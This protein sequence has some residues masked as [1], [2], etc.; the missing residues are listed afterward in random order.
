LT[1]VCGFYL[2]VPDINFLIPND[3]NAKGLFDLTFLVGNSDIL[4]AYDNSAS[5]SI[6]SAIEISFSN[7]FAADLGTGLTAGSE[8]A[9]LNISGLTFNT[10]GRIK[11]QIY[12]SVSTITFPTIIVTGYDKIARNSI[13]RIQF[14]NLQT[15]ATGVT[16]YCKLG[17]SLSYYHYGGVKGYIY[18]PVS[19]VLGPTTAS[20]TPKAISFTVSET[21]SNIVG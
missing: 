18:E 13:V 8:I 1:T 11:C 19:F 5:N 17:V 7:S 15:L 4:P 21:G 14:A 10:M 2:S 3:G 20:N 12:P 6:T 16:D 9:C